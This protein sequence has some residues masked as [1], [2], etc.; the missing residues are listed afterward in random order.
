MPEVRR[1]D[2]RVV[3]SSC[4]DEIDGKWP[5]GGGGSICA[6]VDCRRRLPFCCN[7][8]FAYQDVLLRHT[9]NLVDLLAARTANLHGVNMKATTKIRKRWKQ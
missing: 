9:L 7:V 1:A 3:R 4:D 2:S 8:N 5:P 6:V